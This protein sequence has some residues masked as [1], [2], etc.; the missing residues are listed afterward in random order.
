MRQVYKLG[1]RGD[2]ELKMTLG[3]GQDGGRVCH[4]DVCARY[5]TCRHGVPRARGWRVGR[6]G[7]AEAERVLLRVARSKRGICYLE[8]VKAPMPGRWHVCGA[9]RCKSDLQC[10]D[11]LV[12]I[13]NR[14]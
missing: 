10:P 5:C 8:T 3:G 4:G 12:F 13:Q 9:T 14:T 7:D 1:A 6:K 11:M 2:D